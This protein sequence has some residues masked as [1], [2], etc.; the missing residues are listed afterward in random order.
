[1]ASTDETRMSNWTS[2]E[3]GRLVSAFEWL[4]KEDKKQNPE[5]YLKSQALPT[6]EKRVE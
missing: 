6:D 5:K 3:R 2:E 1:M 4:L